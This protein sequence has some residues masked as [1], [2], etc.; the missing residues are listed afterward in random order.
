MENVLIFLWQWCNFYI[1]RIV[2]EN[3]VL[4][5]FVL[6]AKGKY[7]QKDAQNWNLCL[8]L[9]LYHENTG[10][11]PGMK[12]LKESFDTIKQRKDWRT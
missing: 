4:N 8:Y 10:L 1:K 7:S 2:Q 5:Q 6:W 3:N 9:Y 12:S 11:S